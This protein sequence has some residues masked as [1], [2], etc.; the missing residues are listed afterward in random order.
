MSCGRVSNGANSSSAARTIATFHPRQLS[1]MVNA[2]PR[3]PDA[4]MSR[5][6]RCGSPGHAIEDEWEVLNLAKQR[7]VL[8]RDAVV[9]VEVARRHRRQDN[10]G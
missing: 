9:A 3:P 5:T 7:G 2:A 6:V 10:A 4:P 1:S 8:D